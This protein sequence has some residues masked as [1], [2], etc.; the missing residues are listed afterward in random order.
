MTSTATSI[1]EIPAVRRESVGASKSEKAASSRVP[2]V[3]L[4]NRSRCS[5][6]GN[7]TSIGATC[8]LPVSRSFKSERRSSIRTNAIGSFLTCGL[9]AQLS[10]VTSI[11][12]A[13]KL[14]RPGSPDGNRKDA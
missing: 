8:G 3:A 13:A 11:A 6:V 1:S 7:G 14:V 12:A 5:T 10:S 9:L 2:T 4:M